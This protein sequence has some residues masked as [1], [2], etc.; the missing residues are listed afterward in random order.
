MVK[1]KINY[2][3]PEI[4]EL[5]VG[6]EFEFH[7]GT[8]KGMFINDPELQKVSDEA[9]EKI[10]LE[11]RKLWT[12]ETITIDPWVGRDMKSAIQ[13]LQNGQMRTKY[14][15]KEDI[16]GL[17][18]TKI[19]G[20]S[21]PFLGQTVE[22]FAK[23]VGGGGFNDGGRFI[24]VKYPKSEMI[25]IHVEYESSYAEVKEQLFSGKCKSINEL[26]KICQLLEIK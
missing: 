23:K 5:F 13:V 14:L 20:Y 19:D 1:N 17:G 26:R 7:S 22:A 12:K 24:I 16:E 25:E 15:G 4:S 2:Y 10:P 9:L 18:F 8:F 11:N 3:T 6:Y 21:H